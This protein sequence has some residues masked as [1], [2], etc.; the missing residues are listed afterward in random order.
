MA[1]MLQEA[2]SQEELEPVATR[3]FTPRRL[4]LGTCVGLVVAFVAAYALFFTPDSPPALTLSSTGTSATTAPAGVWS[5]GSGS[6]AGYR[7]REKLLRLPAPNDAVGRTDAVTGTFRLVPAGDAV[8]VPSGMRIDVDL[9]SLK[10][11]EDRR[12]DHMHTMAIETDR[13]PTATFVSTSDLVVHPDDASARML[14]R[15][16]LT[17]HGVTRTVDIPVQ[18]QYDGNRIEV[19]GSLS[20]PWA[21]FDMV[22]PNLSYVTVEADPTM[23]FQLFF[24]HT[25]P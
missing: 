16:D 23:E 24:D 5:V 25:A 7:V 13:F 20:F 4:L 22:Q 6:V 3:W 12:D 14:V 17:L 18:A 9:A 10:S 2:T 19:V 15:G 1:V 21:M 11:D 8:V